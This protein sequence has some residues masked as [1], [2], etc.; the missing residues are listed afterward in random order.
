MPTDLS[1]PEPEISAKTGRPKRGHGPGRPFQKGQS[2]NPGG[3]PSNKA[4]IE[5]LARQFTEAAIAAL[6]AALYDPRSRVAAAIA[7]LDRGY[8]KPRQSHVLNHHLPVAVAS[9]AELLAIA[10]SGGSEVVTEDEEAEEEAELYSLPD[11]VVH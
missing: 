1:A 4:N 5:Q 9:D 10:L 6:A 8:G 3:R 2:G 7:L 11:D